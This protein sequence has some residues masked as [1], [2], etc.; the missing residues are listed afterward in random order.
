MHWTFVLS[1]LNALQE[2]RAQR[3]KQASKKDLDKQQIESTELKEWQKF[4]KS[5]SPKLLLYSCLHGTV[6]IVKYFVS[7]VV[8]PTTRY[9]C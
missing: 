5:Q 3:E 4:W 8:S 9:T 7:K 6:E 1:I 2:R